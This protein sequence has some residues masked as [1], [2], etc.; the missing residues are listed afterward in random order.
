[1]Y[2]LEINGSPNRITILRALGSLHAVKPGRPHLPSSPTTDVHT[3]MYYVTL[4]AKF[5]DPDP[6]RRL[7]TAPILQANLVSFIRQNGANKTGMQPPSRYYPELSHA[8]S[9]GLCESSFLPLDYCILTST[10]VLD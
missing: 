5:G 4:V 6:P 9:V 10:P 7:R 2:S 3:L 8:T 1:M